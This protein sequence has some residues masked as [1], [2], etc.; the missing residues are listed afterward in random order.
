MKTTITPANDKPVTL[1]L[2]EDNKELRENLVGLISLYPEFELLA[3][4]ENCL[5]I[6]GHVKGYEPDVLLMDIEMPLVDGIKGVQIVR[7]FN[8]MLPIIMLTVFEDNKHVLEAIIAGAT[9][10]ILKQYMVTHLAS[11]I[12]EALRGG[13]PMSPVIARMV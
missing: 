5:D 6:E 7:Q 4:F 1:L 13:A 11:A 2:Y 8:E 10:Y 9:G 3:S 12:Q